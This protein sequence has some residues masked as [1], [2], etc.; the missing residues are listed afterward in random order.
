M[1]KPEEKGGRVMIWCYCESCKYH[2][3]DDTCTLNTI[4]VSDREMTAAGFLPQCQDYEEAED[5]LW[6]SLNRVRFAVEKLR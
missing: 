1:L 5:E 4:V 6:K 2:G 3:D